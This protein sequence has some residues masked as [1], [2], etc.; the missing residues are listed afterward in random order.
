MV[1]AFTTATMGTLVAAFATMDIVATLA[2]GILEFTFPLVAGITVVI[3]FKLHRLLPSFALVV[4]AGILEVATS[5]VIVV[6]GI[7]PSLVIVDRTVAAAYHPLVVAFVG[8]HLALVV[9]EHPWVPMTSTADL[10]L[11]NLQIPEH[12]LDLLVFPNLLFVQAIN[13]S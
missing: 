6:V 10:G 2:T 5:W 4:V 12:Q 7:H 1:T 13:Q 9:L 3:A 8:N 11:D